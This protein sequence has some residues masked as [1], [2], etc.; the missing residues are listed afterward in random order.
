MTNIE[1]S[2]ESFFKKSFIIKQGDYGLSTSN[3]ILLRT[4]NRDD[5]EKLR[6]W[7]NE[8]RKSFFYNKLISKKEQ[9]IWFENYLKKPDDYIFIIN[10]NGKEIGCIGFRKLDNE[11]DIYNV[12]LGKKEFAGNNFVGKAMLALCSYLID[13]Y[14]LKITCKV[15]IDNPAINW[16]KK[17]NFF[18][19]LSKDN[20][21]LMQFDEKSIGKGNYNII[22]L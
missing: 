20:Y 5:I 22:S 3:E 21:V 7:K 11:I 6:K 16:Y 13:K 10:V 4:I 18:E 8:N 9:I 2:N 1:N 14:K 12:I 19:V 15:L 17:N